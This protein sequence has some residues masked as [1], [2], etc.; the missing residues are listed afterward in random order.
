[1]DLFGPFRAKATCDRLPWVLPT[2]IHVVRLRRSAGQLVRLEQSL[3]PLAR[4]RRTLVPR[5]CIREADG[6]E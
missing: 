6:R 4:L 1:M 2:A 3:G 5:I